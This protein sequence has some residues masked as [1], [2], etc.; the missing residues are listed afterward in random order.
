MR[1]AGALELRRYDGGNRILLSPLASRFVKGA[2]KQLGKLNLDFPRGK[3]FTADYAAPGWANFRGNGWV[4]KTLLLMPEK[5]H[6]QALERGTVWSTCTVP[7]AVAYANLAVN[8]EGRKVVLFELQSELASREYFHSGGGVGEWSWESFKE[9]H[10]PKYKNWQ[11]ALTAAAAKLAHEKGFDFFVASPEEQL[12]AWHGLG[13][14]KETANQIYRNT[15]SKVAGSFGGRVKKTS[16]RVYA[17][18]TYGRSG[19]RELSVRK[20]IFPKKQ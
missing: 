8:E 19:W 16:V 17:A 14:S 15:P 4:S 2:R 5:R 10:F 12:Q 11:Y 7:G 20:F 3:L 1:G 9:K 6:V 13:L 18:P